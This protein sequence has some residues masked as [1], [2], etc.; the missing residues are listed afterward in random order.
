MKKILLSSTFFILVSLNG[1]MTL[2]MPAYTDQMVAPLMLNIR[3]EILIDQ[4]EVTVK[5]WLDFMFF[6]D[7]KEY[8]SFIQ[9]KDLSEEEIAKLVSMKFDKSLLPVESEMKQFVSHL[10]SLDNKD[11][12]AIQLKPD[13]GSYTYVT[14][15]RD[16]LKNKKYRENIR[17]LLDR[18]ITGISYEQALKYCEWRTE[19]DSIRMYNPNY[20]IKGLGYG[21]I[22]ENYVYELPSPEDYDEFLSCKDSLFLEDKSHSSFNYKNALPPAKKYVKYELGD[23]GSELVR[24]ASTTQYPDSTKREIILYDMRGNAAEMTNVK[25]IAKGGSYAHYAYQ[26]YPGH[27]IKYNKPHEWLGFRCIGRRNSR[28]IQYPERNHAQV[29]GSWICTKILNSKLKESAGKF[30]KSGEYIKFE[31]KNNILNITNSPYDKSGFTMTTDIDMQDST[32]LIPSLVHTEF[33]GIESEYRIRNIS[34]N[35]M[36]LTTTSINNQEINYLFTRQYESSLKAESPKVID[37]GSILIAHLKSDTTGNMVQ[38]VSGYGIKTKTSLLYQTPEFHDENY[39]NFGQ[40]VSDNFQFPNTY[41]FDSISRELILDLKVAEDG[42]E[43][44]KIVKG[45]S[46]AIDNRLQE[47]LLKSKHKWKPVKIGNKVKTQIIRLHFFFYYGNWT[48]KMDVT[49]SRIS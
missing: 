14:I 41:S 11:L 49:R 29:I 33:K 18:P 44:V 20:E 40:F 37:C 39:V 15:P 10:I 23:Y 31:F 13:I 38:K 21:T 48:M 36:I 4:T 16:S 47:V 2:L 30:G 43:M 7:L 6:N 12:V 45:C 5:N 1:C 34:K 19:L 8:P 42:A 26:A 24:V 17:R 46:P 3:N 27:E 35:N 28:S 25:G 22:Y 32:I 9:M